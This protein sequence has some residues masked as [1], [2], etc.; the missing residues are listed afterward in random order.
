[1]RLTLLIILKRGQQ[2][3]FQ[4]TWPHMKAETCGK[5][6][7]TLDVQAG[8]LSAFPVPDMRCNSSLLHKRLG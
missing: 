2:R 5:Y 4:L 8:P 3:M 6:H 1:M 7:K